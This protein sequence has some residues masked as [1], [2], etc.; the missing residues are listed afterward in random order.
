MPRGISLQSEIEKKELEIEGEDFFNRKDS[1][2]TD[3]GWEGTD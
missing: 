1:P 2:R 3:F